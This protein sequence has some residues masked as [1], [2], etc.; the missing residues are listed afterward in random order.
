MIA[1]FPVPAVTN[2]ANQILAPTLNWKMHHQQC[3]VCYESIIRL[4][5]ITATIG[6]TTWKHLDFMAYPRSRSRP[7]PKECPIRTG[8]TFPKLPRS[9]SIAR[10]PA[11]HSAGG[12]Y[13]LYS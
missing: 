1:A 2:R 7:I 10:R 12:A 9:S 3:P 4:E 11:P 6:W 5:R 8:K 13:R